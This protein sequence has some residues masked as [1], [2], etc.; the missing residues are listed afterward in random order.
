MPPKVLL[1][2]D[3][4]RRYQIRLAERLGKTLRELE[5]TIGVGEI[6]EWIAFDELEVENRKARAE[7]AYD[8][9]KALHRRF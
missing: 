1:R 7:Q 4:L 5:R 6:A 3:P 8:A 2:K 9:G